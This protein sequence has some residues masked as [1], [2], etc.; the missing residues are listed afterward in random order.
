MG[1]WW[2]VRTTDEGRRRQW[3]A[4]EP[5]LGCLRMCL[6]ALAVGQLGGDGAQHLGA[7]L[8]DLDQAAA[9]LKIVN[10]QRR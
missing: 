10:A 4:R 6:Q 2:S 5:E 8:A 1:R 7:G 9:L 3:S